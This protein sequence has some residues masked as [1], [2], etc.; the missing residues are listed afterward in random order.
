MIIYLFKSWFSPIMTLAQK[1]PLKEE[2]LYRPV[3]TEESENLTNQL[4]KL[5]K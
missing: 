5:I 2:D 4:E 3:P 1:T